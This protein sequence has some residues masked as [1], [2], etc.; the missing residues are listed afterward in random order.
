[1]KYTFWFNDREKQILEKR[2]GESQRHI[3]LKTLAY[4]L[5][6]ALRPRIEERVLQGRGDYKPDVVVTGES[7]V[8]THWIDCGQIA[9]RKVD[10][11]TRRLPDARIIVVKATVGEMESYAREV[12]KKVR[13]ADRVEYLAFDN[14]FTPNLIAVMGHMNYLRWRCQNSRLDLT[15]NERAFSSRLWRWDSTQGCAA[16]SDAFDQTPSCERS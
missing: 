6:H 13:R 16:L 10:D 12:A 5:H 1:M 15:L 3:I 2:G 7:G 8:I 14:E 4:I 11:L 9:V